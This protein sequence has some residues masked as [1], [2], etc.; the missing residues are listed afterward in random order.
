MPLLGMKVNRR[1][2]IRSAS[3]CSL[4]AA[5]VAGFYTWRVEPH[6]V[7]VVQRQMPLANLPDSLVGKRLV[8]ITD[9]HVGHVVEYDYLQRAIDQTAELQ[10]DLVM[11]TGDLMTAHHT[12]CIEPAVRLLKRLN[13]DNCAIFVTPGNHDYGLHVAQDQ[14][15][16]MLFDE[17]RKVGIHGLRNEQIDYQGLQIVGCDEWMARRFHPQK[18]FA[19]FDVSRPGIALTHNPDT[20]DMPGWD[21]FEG[22]VLAGH[23]HGGQ[24]RLPYFGAPILPIQNRRY[25][26]GEVEVDSVRR[27]YVNRGLG[28]THRVRFMCSPEITQFDLTAAV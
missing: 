17:L 24:C 1:Q 7:D 8:H 5:G 22:W 15:V 10:P 12:E 26:A 28:Y 20:L 2:F 13:P 6:W 18:A 21:G 11:V 27:L 9:L 4:G 19:Q 16:T 25:E 14:V 3:L 23:T